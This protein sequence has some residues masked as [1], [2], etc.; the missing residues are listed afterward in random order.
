MTLPLFVELDYREVAEDTRLDDIIAGYGGHPEEYF[1]EGQIPGDKLM[2]PEEPRP[3]PGIQVPH[4]DN[5]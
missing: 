4:S 2:S 5:C 3:L 1:S